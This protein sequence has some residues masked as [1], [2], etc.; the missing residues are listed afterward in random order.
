MSC[1]KLTPQILS[2]SAARIEKVEMSAKR[3]SSRFFIGFDLSVRLK[4]K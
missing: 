3:I 2:P 4:N 1:M